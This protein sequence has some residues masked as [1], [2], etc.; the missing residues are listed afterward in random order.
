ME[1][2][3]PPI[4]KKFL[5]ASDFAKADVKEILSFY[6]LKKAEKKEVNQ[7]AN[8]VLYQKSA[9]KFTEQVLPF[10]MQ[11][12]PLT[13][14]APMGKQQWLIGMNKYNGNIQIGRYD[15][16]F[17]GILSFQSGQL[18][19]EKLPGLILKGAIKKIVP[20]VVNGKRHY[21]VVKNNDSCQLIAPAS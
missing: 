5:K 6:D 1:K 9:G 2:K 14:I 12:S 8:L 21:L 10:T 13:A 7:F 4:K 16:D 3:L 18:K 20:I 17:G 19:Y 15:A 11:F